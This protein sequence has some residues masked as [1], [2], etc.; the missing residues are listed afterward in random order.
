MNGLKKNKDTGMEKGHSA[1]VEEMLK[2]ALKEREK[3]RR[4]FSFLD[5]GCGNGWVVRM[6]KINEKAMGVDGSKKMIAKA[7]AIKPYCEYFLANIDSL[8]TS[9]NSDLI[10]SMEVLYY[11]S[12]EECVNNVSTKWLANGGRFIVGIDHYFENENPIHGRKKLE[13][14]DDAKRIRMVRHFCKVW[15]G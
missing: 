4:F 12:P 11:D 7:R 14:H 5:L 10:H 8:K 2:H 13:H 6:P 1:S 3:N 15:V 9:Q